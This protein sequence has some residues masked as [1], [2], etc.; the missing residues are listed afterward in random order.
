MFPDE[1]KVDQAIGAI[2]TRLTAGEDIRV[3]GLAVVARGLHDKIAVQDITAERHG[4]VGAGAFLGGLTG[5]AG[6]PLGTAIGIAAG[7]LLGWSAALVNEQA[8]TEF[9]NRNLCEMAPVGA[10]SWPR[11]RKKRRSLSTP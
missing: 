11:L 8:F 5:L 7:A 9:A 4:T 3:Y 1:A 6:G 2:I 10:L